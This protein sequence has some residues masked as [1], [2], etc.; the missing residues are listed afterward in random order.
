[1]SNRQNQREYERKIREQ[2]NELVNN[3]SR[4]YSPDKSKLGEYIRQARGTR[5]VRQFASELAV[6]PSTISRAE[7]GKATGISLEL[8]LEIATHAEPNSGITF[9]KILEADGMKANQGVVESNL[10]S[11]FEQFAGDIIRGEL[12]RENYS[13]TNAFETVL[14]QDG[15]AEAPSLYIKTDAI[16]D[17]IWQIKCVRSTRSQDYIY[18]GEPTQKAVGYINEFM[19]WF[20]C[21]T[22]AIKKCSVAVENERVYDTVKRL[23][24]AKL[25]DR[26]IDNLISVIL[27]DPD[28][29]YVREEW[30]LPTNINIP[31]I[32][33]GNP[34]EKER[35]LETQK[36][37]QTTYG[38]YL[39]IMKFL[40]SE[41]KKEFDKAKMEYD[42]NPENNETD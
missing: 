6:S 26:K 4:T 42:I 2:Y 19:A 38:E 13:C 40:E 3:Y 41:A 35:I 32:F 28:R 33:S 23:F 37:N 10:N 5:S 25:G 24:S 14:E 31:K 8:L 15:Y 36:A 34:P 11:D 18:V 20:Y 12:F 29:R 7:N 16:K 17:G 27:I 39:A 22:D 9:E 30:Y 1:M 21:G